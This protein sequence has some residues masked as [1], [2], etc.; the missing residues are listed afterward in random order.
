VYAPATTPASPCS[1]DALFPP[2]DSP[3]LK[4]P[5]IAILLLFINLH[6]SAMKLLLFIS[7]AFINTMGITQPS[8]QAA[9]RAAFFIVA[10]LAGVLA[11]VVTI[12]V[13]A[14]HWAAHR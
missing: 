13:L 1:K 11:A 10:M 7:N 9:K 3:P 4:S 12:A 2:K 14:I 6:L 8:P 5:Q